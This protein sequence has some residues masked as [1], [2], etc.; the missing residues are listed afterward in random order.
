M[1]KRQQIKYIDSDNESITSDEEYIPID[2]VNSIS[3][4]DF[5]KNIRE[6][7]KNYKKNNFWKSFLTFLCNFCLVLT[8]YIIT[9]I[10]G[11]YIINSI[12]PNY[13]N[14][15]T[16]IIIIIFIWNIS[17]FNTFSKQYYKNLIS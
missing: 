8:H 7:N 14:Y 9:A 17:L 5:H 16:Y 11:N 2:N 4:K 1:R 6:F 3:L 12:K 10:T 15:H 13:I